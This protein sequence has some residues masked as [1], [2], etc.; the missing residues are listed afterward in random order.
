MVLTHAELAIAEF[1]ECH[2]HFCDLGGDHV[3]AGDELIAL[4]FERTHRLAP[5]EDRE[6]LRFDELAG[7]VEQRIQDAGLNGIGEIGRASCR[8]RVCNGV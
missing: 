4:Q 7:F 1:V 6:A 5:G 2:V 3:V 8:E